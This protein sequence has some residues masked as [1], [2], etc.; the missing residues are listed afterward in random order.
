MKA[1]EPSVVGIDVSKTTLVVS[2][3]GEGKA[4]RARQAVARDQASLASLVGAMVRDGVT[5]VA[6]EST[7][8]YEL[9]V[10]QALHAA[11]IKVAQLPPEQV[12]A[13]ARSQRKRAKTDAIDSEIIADYAAVTEV[14]LWSPKS[15]KLAG[16]LA[17]LRHRDTL[18][19]ERTREKNRLEHVTEPMVV[20]SMRQHVNWLTRAARAMERDAVAC[21]EA[22]PEAAA[23]FELLRTVPGVGNLTAARIVVEL[24]EVG[25]IDKRKASSLAGLAPMNRDS[26]D[27]KG[28]RRCA[29]GRT[30]VKTALYQAALAAIIHNPVIRALY[31][32][33]RSAGKEPK[34]ALTACAHK[35]LVILCAMVRHG[36]AW[37]A[38]RHPSLEALPDVELA[39]LTLEAAVLGVEPHPNNDAHR[40]A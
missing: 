40:P 30:R 3:Y 9:T 38:S 33:L 8:G 18:I 34:V 36:K 23:L 16:A 11:G 29:P 14:E 21:I 17:M 10:L 32:R 4:A 31:V 15:P 13:F 39:E 37:D 26:G 1:R 7:G 24:P 22:E 35:L 6:V 2:S 20:E 12:K 19:Q 5:L 28:K 27:V 25:S